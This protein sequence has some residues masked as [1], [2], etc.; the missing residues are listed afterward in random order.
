[1][2]ATFAGNV[3]LLWCLG[4]ED[5]FFQHMCTMTFILNTFAGVPEQQA[6]K[7]GKVE[8]A[9]AKIWPMQL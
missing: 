3:Y 2:Q 7:Q 8:Q 9:F 6:C 1:M 5:Q 4:K